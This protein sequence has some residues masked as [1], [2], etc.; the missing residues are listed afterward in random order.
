MP[1][2]LSTRVNVDTMKSR[3]SLEER[4]K[5]PTDNYCLDKVYSLLLLLLLLLSLLLFAPTYINKNSDK[6]SIF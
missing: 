4:D 1:S 2:H 5:I 6:E 3:G